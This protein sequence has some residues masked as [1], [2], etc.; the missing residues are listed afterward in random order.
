MTRT[1]GCAAKKDIPV[2]LIARRAELDELAEVI[3]GRLDLQDPEHARND[4]VVRR[5]AAARAP[6]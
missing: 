6:W 1:P 2:K 5:E 3:H 4:Q